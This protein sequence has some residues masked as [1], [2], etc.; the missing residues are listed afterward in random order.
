MALQTPSSKH[1]VLI[2]N[3]PENHRVLGDFRCNESGYDTA[4]QAL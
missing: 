1:R 3:N 2:E 4:G